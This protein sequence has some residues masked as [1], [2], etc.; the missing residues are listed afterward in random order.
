MTLFSIETEIASAMNS[1]VSLVLK[2][3]STTDKT[4]IPEFVRDV[5]FQSR[6]FLSTLQNSRN[7]R[8]VLKGLGQNSFP[9]GHLNVMAAIIGW[10]VGGAYE[11]SP[12]FADG[13]GNLIRVGEP[14][15]VNQR[16]RRDPVQAP[17]QLL[18]M[19]LSI[20][21]ECPQDRDTFFIPTKMEKY[22]FLL[23]AAVG[24]VMSLLS[25]TRNVCIPC[26]DGRYLTI[27]SAGGIGVGKERRLAPI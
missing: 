21:T 6:S 14:A 9:L 19:A 12:L 24:H 1:P 20:A 18:D 23:W 27:V 3:R 2:N 10:Q 16:L 22:P 5:W 17:N 13:G 11:T 8:F 7:L 25:V 26:P 4:P 15:Y